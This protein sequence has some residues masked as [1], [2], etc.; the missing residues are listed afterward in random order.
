MGFFNLFKKKEKE[1]E[2]PKDFDVLSGEGLIGYI[3]A[4]LEEPTNENVLKALEKIAQ[5]D[6]DLEHLTAEGELPWGWHTHNKEF[7]SKIDSDYSRSLNRWLDSRNKSPME[8]LTALKKFV[9][10]LERLEKTC[11]SKGECFEFYFREIIASQDYI[12]KRKE[13]LSELEKNIDSL[14]EAYDR[15][16]QNL[17]GLDEKIVQKLI[18]NDGIIQA[19]FI[20]LFDPSIKNEV[21]EKLYYWDKDGKI[22]RQ[23]SGRS[24]ILHYIK[25]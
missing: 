4:N 15:K 12:Q 23:K 8:E 25:K 1:N 14:Q 2:K 18:E 17:I 21:S 22:T 5:P 7:I 6:D 11:K 3:Q 16:K 24:Y 19:D 20:K 9:S 10:Y 13:E